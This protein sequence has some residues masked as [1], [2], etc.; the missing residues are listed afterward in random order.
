MF[1][2][3]NESTAPILISMFGR[4]MDLINSVIFKNF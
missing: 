2:I 4:R 1:K 3:K